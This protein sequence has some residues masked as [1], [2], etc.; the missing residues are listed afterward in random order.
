M[1]QD[2]LSIIFGKTVH[3]RPIQDHLVGMKPY[4]A[5]PYQAQLALYHRVFM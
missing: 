1:P 4:E 5:L 2:A 3:C